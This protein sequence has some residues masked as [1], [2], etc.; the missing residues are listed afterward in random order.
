MRLFQNYFRLLVNFETDGISACLFQ[1]RR[2]WRGPAGWYAVQVRH[3]EDYLISSLILR[4]SSAWLHAQLQD[5][6]QS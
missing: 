6:D 3:Y 5:S 1:C 4:I 2:T